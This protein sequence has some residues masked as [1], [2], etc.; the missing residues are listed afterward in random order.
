MDLTNPCIWVDNGRHD[1]DSRNDRTEWEQFVTTMA[2]GARTE[3]SR[4][5]EF[6]RLYNEVD[7]YLRRR[8]GLD[9]TDGFSF[10]V[11]RAAERDSAVRR[12]RESLI[13]YGDLRNAIIHNRR[14]PDEI[15]AEPHPDAVADLRNIVSMVTSPPKLIPTFSVDLRLFTVDEPLIAALTYMRSQDYSQVVVRNGEE[16]DLLTTEGIARWFER[17]ADE[18]IISVR[19]TTV[20]DAVAE[21]PGGSFRLMS[22]GASVFDAQDSFSKLPTP[23]VSRLNAIIITHSG[24]LAEKPLGIVT[25]WDL[26]AFATGNGDR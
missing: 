20:G 11:K 22:R 8:T 21:Q 2:N 18:D 3:R 12:F 10:V 23:N 19:E 7:D 13:G 9:S 1:S 6:L 25:P 5:D 17:Q 4:A 16:L 14:Y 26:I 15:I 24:K